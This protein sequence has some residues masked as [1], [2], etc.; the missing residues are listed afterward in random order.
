MEGDLLDEL[1]R[2]EAIDPE[3]YLAEAIAFLDSRDLADIKARALVKNPQLESADPIE[4]K[5]MLIARL[6]SLDPVEFKAQEIERINMK[7]KANMISYLESLNPAE[8]DEDHIETVESLEPVD[9]M[10]DEIARMK[11]NMRRARSSLRLI[12]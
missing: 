2:L 5:D 6:E 1:E 10:V 3:E 4:I 8:I 12:Q 7:I 11:M 9:Y